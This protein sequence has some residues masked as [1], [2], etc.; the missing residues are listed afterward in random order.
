MSKRL[1]ALFGLSILVILAGCNGTTG[2]QSPTGT[3]SEIITQNDTDKSETVFNGVELPDGTT[4]SSINQTEVLSSH[5]SLLAN[6]DYQ[7][8]INLTHV[9]SGRITNTTTVIASNRSRRQLQLQSDLP[10]RSLQEYYTANQSMSRRE[11]GGS[12]TYNTDKVDS[13]ESVHRR[14]ARGGSLLTAI[15]AAS[16]FTAVNTTT[17][18][19]YDAVRYNVTDVSGVNSTRLP[20][21]IQQFNGS[22]VIGER[23]IIWKA[24]LLTVGTRN[25]T[26]E[27]MA[28]KYQT[29]KYG[30]VRVKK[31]EWVQN[32]TGI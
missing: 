28:Q 8:E 30:N 29:L 23:G 24:T 3:Q 27:A 16:K 13:F 25:E 32:R 11:V 10:G 12:V 9:R 4:A 6:Q 5:Q 19:G 14:E 18:D 22:I 20:S 2:P 26:V 7:V 1:I 15:L 17:V 21:T 31:P